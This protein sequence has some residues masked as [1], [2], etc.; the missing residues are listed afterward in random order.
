MYPTLVT[1]HVIF[2][3]IWLSFFIIELVLRK[4][5]E[6]NFEADKVSNYLMFSNTFG[7]IGSLGILATGIFIVTM[8]SQYGFFDMTSNHWL[9][10]KQ[11]IL[12]IILIITTSLV[13]PNSKE[14]REKLENKKLES[15][16]SGLKK[17]FRANQIIHYMVL[18]N[19]IFAVTHRFYG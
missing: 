16:D 3:G 9:A 19:L 1:F 14:V 6:K 7:I 12:L 4:Q 15:I 11:I 13:I 5:I 17:L 2:A 8:N 10:T 18:V